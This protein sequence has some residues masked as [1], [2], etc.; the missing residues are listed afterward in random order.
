MLDVRT[1]SCLGVMRHVQKKFFNPGH[2]DTIYTLGEIISKMNSITWYHGLEYFWMQLLL[3]MSKSAALPL[4][5]EMG[6]PIDLA[7]RK[8]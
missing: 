2:D 4:C 3:E 7:L 8:V 6:H 5:I 1:G